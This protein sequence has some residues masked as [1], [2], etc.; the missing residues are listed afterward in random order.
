MRLINTKNGE[1]WLLGYSLCTCYALYFMI[2]ISKT[3]IPC[4]KTRI[5]IR[6]IRMEIF[7]QTN[8]KTNKR[9]TRW[10]KRAISRNLSKLKRKKNENPDKP[11]QFKHKTSFYLQVLFTFQT[12]LNK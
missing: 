6:I 7:I 12:V 2:K 4:I 11:E 1:R 5:F 10:K 8:E 9:I 3:D